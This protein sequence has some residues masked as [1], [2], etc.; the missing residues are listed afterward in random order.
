MQAE[1]GN[2]QIASIFAEFAA[3]LQID[4]EN[5][6]KVR[7]YERAAQV[8]ASLT[9]PLAALARRGELKAAPGIGTGIA[10]KIEAILKTGTFPEREE[11]RKKIPASVLEMLRIPEVGPKTVAFVYKQLGIDSV[12]KL[13]EACRNQLLRSVKGFGAKTEQ[14]ILK[15]IERMRAFTGRT[16]LAIA[17]PHALEVVEAIRSGA[18]VNQIQV[19]GSLRRMKET[20]GDIDILVTS[21]NAGAV[22]DRFTSL[23]VVKEIQ[24]KG[25]TKSS[26]LSHLD[27]QID[28]RVVEPDSFGA[29]LQ[30]FTGSK[31]HNVK[32]R[33]MGIR[34]GLKLSEYGVFNAKTNR[35]L[36]GATEEEMYSPLGL[37]VM[38]PELREDLG[39]IEAA[40]EDR[41]PKLVE[42]RHM[43]GDV[44][45]HTNASDGHNTIE[46]MA[47]AATERGYEYIVIADHSRSSAY[48]GGLTEEQLVKHIAQIR[49]VNEAVERIEVM[50]GCEVDIRTDGSL[51]YPDELLAQ[52][53][54]VT[55]S[56]HSG[57]K[58]DAA[59]MTDRII[60][61]MRNPLADVI[62]HP[63]G[64][65]IGQRDPYEVDV[66]RLL[67]AAAELGCA[68]EVNAQPQRL[69]LND[70][71]CRR[72]KELGVKL[73]ISTDAHSTDQ[74]DLMSYGVA[75]ARRGWIEPGDVLNTLPLEELLP[76]RRRGREKLAT[77]AARPT[78]RSRARG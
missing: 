35:R 62:G 4:E 60:Q 3:M 6:F 10:E 24:A 77:S 26:I 21:T 33:D 73:C 19:A 14:N 13:E 36:G 23:P 69:D 12:D 2:Q 42:M 18:P 78:R 32:L 67:Q 22:M 40:L 5:P 71:H 51:D 59:T 38:A 30:Y 64:R 27:I 47:V 25:D 37:P 55:A 54:F 44:H 29:A 65:L 11:M 20:I 75:T 57:F 50:A 48:A 17:Y 16:P 45:V 1:I 31:P 72:A 8:I 7:A 68:M 70:V 63:T 15:G 28:V 74:L 39:E 43:K 76:R 9:E 41:L 49:K 53:D 66:E 52:L 46:Q 34:K 58:M 56:V 61:A